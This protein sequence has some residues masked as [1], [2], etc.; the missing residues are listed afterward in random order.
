MVLFK[1]TAHRNKITLDVLPLILVKVDAWTELWQ[2]T[3][4]SQHAIN[5]NNEIMK[6][7]GEECECFLKNDDSPFSPRVNS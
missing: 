6:K 1:A 4:E 2:K 5:K 3:S 7:R